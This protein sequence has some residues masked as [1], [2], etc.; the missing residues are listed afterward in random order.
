MGI[1]EQFSRAHL[2]WLPE[3][4]IGFYPVE[5]MPYDAAYFAKYQEMAQ[6]EMGQQLTAAR[7]ALVNKYTDGKVLDIGIGSGAF[8]EA[9]PYT[10]GYDVNPTGINWLMERKRYR[11][12]LRG[13]DA[14]TFWDSLE[15][16][17]DPAMILQGAKEYVF[18]SCPIYDNVMHI[19]RSKHYRPTEHVWYWTVHGLFEFMSRYG[20]E[21]VEMNRM[22]TALGREDI[23][24]FV[25]KRV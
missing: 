5:S 17:H 11:H 20:F 25:F 22:E 15:H 3:L 10:W 6:T 12:P 4:G 18:V 9:R 1:F 8:V 13:A 2:Q 7:V 16:I 14:L 23:G 19:L 24:T 21:P